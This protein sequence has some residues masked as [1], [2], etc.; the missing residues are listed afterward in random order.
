MFT[1]IVSSTILH[2]LT[3]HLSKPHFFPP[4][5]FKQRL[6]NQTPYIRF[7]IVFSFVVSYQRIKKVINTDCAMALN[8]MY[9]LLIDVSRQALRIQQQ[10]LN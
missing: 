5:F 2:F 3:S 4:P 1:L 8:S 9:V 10:N 7:G 6:E